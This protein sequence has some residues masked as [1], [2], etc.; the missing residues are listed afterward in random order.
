MTD[1][2]TDSRAGSESDDEPEGDLRHKAKRAGAALLHYTVTGILVAAALAVG[3]WGLLAPPE[4][5]PESTATDSPTAIRRARAAST[6][7]RIEWALEVHRI[8]SKRFPASLGGLVDRGLLRSD[9]LSYPLGGRH[10]TYA[11]MDGGFRLTVD[12]IP[13]E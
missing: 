7:T 9:D 3:V 10:W 11:T 13:G 6:R 8:E 12:N 2:R 5:N 4:P 1:R